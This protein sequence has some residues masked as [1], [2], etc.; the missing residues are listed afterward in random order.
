MSLADLRKAYRV[1]VLTEAELPSDPLT[2]LARWLAEAGQ[3]GL[4][5][6]NAMAL[7]TAD[8]QGR[9]SVRMVLL[10]GL[11]AEGL[12]FYTNLQ[13]RKGLELAVN[14]LAAVCFYWEALER[15]VRVE[16]PVAQVSRE[17]AETY[18]RSRPYGSQ[19]AAWA[20]EQSRELPAR[21]VLEA[22]WQALSAQYPPGAVPLP[23]TWGGY[24][25]R[26]QRI[27]FWQGREDRLHDRFLYL[28][29][30]ERWTVRRLYP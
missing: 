30:G 3:T 1:G 13:S 17:E 27:E 20:S 9:P 16:G 23:P 10:K 25:L 8:S 24:R 15:Q 28:S 26:P 12:V 29:E 11:D 14:P 7:A 21:E 4:A 5:E 18:F 2:L 22:R 6:P 19:L